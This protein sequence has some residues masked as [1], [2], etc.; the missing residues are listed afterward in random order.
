MIPHLHV[1]SDQAEGESKGK[2]F[3]RGVLSGVVEPLAAGISG[4]CNY[5]IVCCDHDGC[6]LKTWIRWKSSG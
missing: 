4:R 2:A 1:G 3:L 5:D 6:K